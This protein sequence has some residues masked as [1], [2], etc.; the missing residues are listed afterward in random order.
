MS[1]IIEMSNGENEI[2]FIFFNQ[3]IWLCG[4]FRHWEGNGTSLQCFLPE[5]PILREPGE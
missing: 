3:L 2:S 5:N 4:V 1:N